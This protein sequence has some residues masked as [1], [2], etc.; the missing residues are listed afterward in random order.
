M[1][2]SLAANIPRR[3]TYKEKDL[4][5]AATHTHTHTRAF[6][7]S[8]SS[9]SRSQAQI[10]LCVVLSLI[11]ALCNNIHKHTGTPKVFLKL[12]FLLRS[13]PSPFLLSHIWNLTSGILGMKQATTKRKIKT[14]WGQTFQRLRYIFRL[15]KGL[16]CETFY[17]ENLHFCWD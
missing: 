3:S 15:V 14:D 8:D 10:S 17:L 11:T 2:D 13:P 6:H 7:C 1:P 9:P 12:A 16:C 5:Q 4:L